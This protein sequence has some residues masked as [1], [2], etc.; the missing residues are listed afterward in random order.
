MPGTAIFDLDRTITRRPT[1]T[2]FCFFACR[3]RAGFWLRLPLWMGRGVALK[4]GLADRQAYKRYSLHLLSALDAGVL[5]ARARD[6]AERD[7]GREIRPGSRA[8]IGRHR[9]QGDRLVLATACCDFLAR[10]YGA[11]LGFDAV[12]A[13][14]TRREARGLGFGG[15]NCYGAEKLRQVRDLTDAA[16][17]ARP[18]HAYSD[19][20]SDLALLEFAD[21][22]HAVNPDRRLRKAAKTRQIAIV[23]YDRSDDR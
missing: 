2:R 21:H 3:D 15:E 14:A 16:P 19:H 5:E 1:W 11:L 20:I 22:G 8:A 10:H 7:M 12:L 17:F 6:F 9:A 23:D 13:T 18:F 4:L